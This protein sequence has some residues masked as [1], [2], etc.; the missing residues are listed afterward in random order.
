MT[1]TRIQ[2]QLHGSPLTA[3]AAEEE[4]HQEFQMM[5]LK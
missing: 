5:K 3:Q 1:H 4:I 2:T